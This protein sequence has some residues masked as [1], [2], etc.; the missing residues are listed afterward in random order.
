MSELA[1]DTEA[2]DC[3]ADSVRFLCK[4]GESMGRLSFVVGGV[5]TV[6]PCRLSKALWFAEDVLA[7]AKARP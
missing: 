3:E 1:K 6:I 5:H 4:S 7:A 2:P